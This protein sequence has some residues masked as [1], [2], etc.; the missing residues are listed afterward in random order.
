MGHFQ[1][2]KIGE[3]IKVEFVEYSENKRIFISPDSVEYK[4]DDYNP[5][6]D[7]IIGT[8]TMQELVIILDFSTNMIVIGKIKLPMRKIK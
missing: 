8:Q 5:E 7:L 2:D 3:G 1:T 4:K 6:F